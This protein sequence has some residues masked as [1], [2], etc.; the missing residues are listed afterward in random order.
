MRSEIKAFGGKAAI[1]LSIPSKKK[2]GWILQAASKK[3]GSNEFDWQVSIRV[4]LD[5]TEGLAL[6]A[7]LMGE[8]LEL[9]DMKKGERTGFYHNA[10][11]SQTVKRVIGGIHGT[12]ARL[13]VSDEAHFIDIAVC[14]KDRLSVSMFIYESATIM[15]GWQGFTS[16]QIRDVAKSFFQRLSSS[17]IQ[18]N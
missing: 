2:D 18:Q 9:M 10:P 7:L 4:G 15:Q 8:S 1:S 17:S 14:P 13:R 12:F 11:G 16:G 5:V 3:E 6:A